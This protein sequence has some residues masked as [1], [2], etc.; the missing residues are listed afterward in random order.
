MLS[1]AKLIAGTKRLRALPKT[2]TSDIVSRHRVINRKAETLRY[3][4]KIRSAT[5][6]AT[7]TTIL[8]LPLDVVDRKDSTHTLKFKTKSG[9]YVY[10]RP[11]TT[12]SPIQVTCSCS[13]YY[14]TWYEWVKRG[15]SHYGPNLPTYER[16][17]SDRPERNP[18][19]SPGL[20]KHLLTLLRDARDEGFV[21]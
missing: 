6:D 4:A 18:L 8:L 3:G 10:L 17:T 13:D 5:G 16:K 20:C 12:R 14:F 7:Y 21:V 2:S 19:H 9:S 1:I 11:A 15:D